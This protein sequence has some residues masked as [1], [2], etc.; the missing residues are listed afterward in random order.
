MTTHAKEAGADD[1]LALGRH[2]RH[3][4]DADFLASPDED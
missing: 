4:N 2:V 1:D 3:D